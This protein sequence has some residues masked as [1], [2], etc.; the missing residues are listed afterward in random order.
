MLRPRSLPSTL[1]IHAVPEFEGRA[2]DANTLLNAKKT[3]NFTTGIT[4]GD[5]GAWAW[6]NKPNL[7]WQNGNASTNANSWIYRDK[8]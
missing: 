5:G 1:H 7:L 8:E 2:R 6:F 4:F 3:R